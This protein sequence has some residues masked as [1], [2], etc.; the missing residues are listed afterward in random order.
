MTI[1][2]AADVQPIGAK[3]TN[4]L[5]MVELGLPVPEMFVLPAVA[6]AADYGALLEWVSSNAENVD[7]QWKLAVRSSSSQEDQAEESKAGH[8]HSEVGLFDEKSLFDA[9]AR[10]QESGPSMGV[11]V[12]GLVD[13]KIAG[14]FFSCDPLSFSKRRSTIAWV[15]GLADGL[16]AGEEAGHL[17]SLDGN[18]S[19][20]EGEWP[21]GTSVLEQLQRATADLIRVF[22]GPVDIE[23]AIDEVDRLWFLQ[24][25]PVVLPASGQV[26]LDESQ[27]FAELPTTILQHHKIRLRRHAAELGINMA[28]AIVIT[29]SSN[30]AVAEHL[31]FDAIGPGA[32]ASIVLLHPEHIECAIMREF[33]PLTD[34]KKPN[35]VE[36]CRRYSIRRYPSR[37]DITSAVSAVLEAGMSQCWTATAIVQAV[38]NASAT[39][40]IRK[41]EQGFVID[42]AKGH[43]VPKGVVT[44]SS[45]FVSADLD[46]FHETWREQKFAYH[47]EG[48]SVVR[49]TGLK[50]QVKLSH[51]ETLQIIEE[52]RPLF[53]AYPE[54]ALEFGIIR[55]KEGVHT[56]L[57]DVAESDVGSI[58]LDHA[59]LLSGV[60]SQGQS[61]GRVMRVDTLEEEPLD[62]HFHDL[63]SDVASSSG[64]SII[65]A[66]KASTELIKVAC[67]PDV[68]GCIFHEASI[69]AHLPV[70]L[71][72]KGIPALILEDRNMFESLQDG[73]RI[74]LDA[75]NRHLKNSDRVSLIEGSK[76]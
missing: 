24:V 8:F 25:R 52:M 11:I 62:S 67:A 56:Y 76:T 32:A 57:I 41:T 13:P 29:R 10:V 58:D 47:F 55:S 2:P 46:E 35:W 39:G 5:K 53:V 7:G 49:E 27:S 30:R 50:S 3:A 37:E 19:V 63:H 43:F 21:G 69:L 18:G 65:V 9:I 74:S 31:S 60:L 14:V 61:E 66:E 40:I 44:T 4:L 16:L 15:E 20:L 23:W 12:Q 1:D 36:K 6:S 26:L 75:S 64:G 71:R 28:P 38:W 45:V 42:I 70:V 73:Q 34:E 51:S 59:M 54:S 48:G 33:A 22:D 17:V 68:R 72:E